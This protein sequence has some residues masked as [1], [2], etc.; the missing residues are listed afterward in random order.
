MSQSLANVTIHVIFS[1]KDRYAFLTPQI[2]PELYAY[3][4]TVL[5]EM[6]SP[7]ILIGGV[8]DHV[9]ILCR[10]SRNHII[11]DIVKTVKLSTSKWLKTKRGMLSKFQWQGGYGAFSVSASQV[12]SVVDYIKNQEEHHRDVSFEDELRRFLTKYGVTFDERYV[13]D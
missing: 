3:M 9:H 8:E 10:L 4:A 11:A 12:A 1:T 7:A 6:D 5:A 2:R 13:W